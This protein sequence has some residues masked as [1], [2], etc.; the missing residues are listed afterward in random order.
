MRTARRSITA[1]VTILVTMLLSAPGASAAAP[2]LLSL[3]EFPATTTTQEVRVN[4]VVSATG[5]ICVEMRVANEDGVWGNWDQCK[6]RPH[7]LSA[8]YGY[9]GVFVQVRNQHL[10]ASNILFTKI[11]YV[12]ET[13]AAP[14]PGDAA[15]PKVNSLTLPATTATRT[16]TAT[17]NATDDKGVTMMRL[18]NEDGNWQAWKPFAANATHTLSLGAGIKGVFVQVR[19]AAGKESNIVFTKTR[20]TTTTLTLYAART[21][22]TMGADRMTGTKKSE[23]IRASQF[24]R[25]RDVIDCGGGRD[26]VI[27]RP[28]DRT[29]NCERV[30]TV[31]KPAS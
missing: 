28:E 19:D 4:P 12:R 14:A 24:D 23:T 6:A 8:G 22:G 9:K 16:I 13:Q 31:R 1:L 11:T 25:K 3:H 20:L 5:G 30:I 17:I 21:T 7:L 18:A 27:K 2:E 26:T 10:Q 29:R 15:A